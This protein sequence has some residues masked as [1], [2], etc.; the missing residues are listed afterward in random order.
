DGS[1]TI[2]GKGSVA[3]AGLKKGVVVNIDQTVHSIASAVEHAERLSG[4][5][6]DRS[7]VVVGGQHVE[8]QNSR[9]AVA[10]SGHTREV[11]REDI[12]RA[13][14][15]ARAVSIPSNREVLHV[16]PRGFVVDGQEGVRDPLG[17]SAIRLEV[18]THIVHG[19]ATA[20]QN[21][22]KCI[23]QA[24]VRVDELVV[25]SLASGEAVLSDTERELGVAVA[26]IG[27]GTT[28]LAV[29]LDG[30]P[31]HTTVVPIGG[32]NVT[33]DLA[34]GLKTNLVAAEQ[35]KLAH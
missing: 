31:F 26:D 8:S 25:E 10:V 24:G 30:S 11:S 21:L 35:L 28:D 4:W 19:A 33:A 16:L 18:E 7:F 15:V 13:T 22:T 1:I 9:G 3:A 23:R 12:A 17:M 6:I 5:K 20:L 29:Y 34:I 27:A 32:M 14:E 2:I